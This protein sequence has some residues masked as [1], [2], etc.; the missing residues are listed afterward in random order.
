[1]FNEHGFH[2][3]VGRLS[4]D[5]QEEEPLIT[6]ATVQ[7]LGKLPE[8]QRRTQVLIADEVHQFSSD[9]SLEALQ[10]FENA[11]FRV[12]FS[13]T[14][15]RN[16]AVHRYRVMSGFGPV[17]TDLNTR[18]LTERRVLAP[19]TAH[20]YQVA[21]P[22]DLSML[23]YQE[24]ET[25]GIATNPHLTES[26]VRLVRDR[27]HGGRILLLVKRLQQGDT[28]ARLIPDALW[29]RGEDSASTRKHIIEQLKSSQEVG[30]ALIG[31]GRR[32]V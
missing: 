15:F 16:S 18:Q 10:R 30:F 21:A 8:L 13:A 27:I 24:A 25:E 2:G 31:V 6:C 12:G 32:I 9:L 19:A 20:F 17:L 22:A 5:H 29:V 14:P 28:L 11:F 23:S 7:S 26:I 4:M 3:K 1:V